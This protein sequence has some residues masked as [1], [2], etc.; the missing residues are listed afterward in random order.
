[1]DNVATRT[2]APYLDIQHVSAAYGGTRV[3]DRV[4]LDVDREAS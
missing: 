3:L 4:S 1:M 2:S